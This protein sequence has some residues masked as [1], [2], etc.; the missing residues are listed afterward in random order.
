MAGFLPVWREWALV[1]SMGRFAHSA[2]FQCI[3][4]FLISIRTIKILVII[5]Q[6]FDIE[7]GMLYKS[8]ENSWLLGMS[9]PCTKKLWEA[10][11]ELEWSLEY[12]NYLTTFGEQPSPIYDDFLNLEYG[13]GVLLNPQ[14]DILE[15]WVKEL[16]EFGIM[17]LT[18]TKYIFELN[19][20]PSGF[21]I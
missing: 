19:R 14:N 7:A 9:L 10:D 13:K 11:S 5:A 2:I 4:H 16:D 20:S 18:T 12:A 3:P 8:C 15:G 6:L 17:T 1:E 21:E